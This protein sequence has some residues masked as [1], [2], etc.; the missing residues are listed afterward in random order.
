MTD[1]ITLSAELSLPNEGATRRLAEDLAAIV[2]VGEVIS[3]KGDLGSGKTTFARYFLRAL[4]DDDDLE[5]PSPTFTLAQTYGFG[6]MD[7]AHYDFYRLEDETEAGELGLDTA[8]ETGIAL[9]EWPQQAPNY[10]PDNALI[11]EI[12]SAGG[13]R[14]SVSL[15]SVRPEVWRDRLARTASIRTFLD[16]SGFSEARRR[17]LT[18]DA[19]SRAYERV[20]Q[21]GRTVILMNAPE[22]SD[23][24]PV[25][26]GLPYSRI[27][28]LA[29][30]V[31]PFVAI[32][33]ELRRQ[34]LSAPEIFAA[35]LDQGL[36]V[37]EDLGPGIVV[38]DGVPMP[39]RYKVA[40]DLL[41]RM[42]AIDWPRDLPLADQ[43]GH[44]VPLYDRTALLIEVELYCDWY[45]PFTTGEDLPAAARSEFLQLWGELVDGL[46]EAETSWVLRDFHSPNLI[47]LPERMAENRIGIIDFQDALIGPTAYDVASLCQ[48]ARVTVDAG[49]EA[50]LVDHYCALRRAGDRPFNELD[51]RSDYAVVAAQRA[52]K[53]LGIFARLNVRDGKPDYLRH[54]PR[55]VDYLNR[56]LTH[57]RLSGVKRWYE[58]NAPEPHSL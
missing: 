10:I 46:E 1:P 50:M 42:H 30:S 57:P 45:V 44:R 17:H 15:S 54:V 5:V 7:A 23:G 22:R 21:N 35:D 41:A 53:V 49:I 43:S 56:V 13:D 31:R 20:H 4:A 37:L 9:I 11:L 16:V 33:G 3:L 51:F 26:D 19:S 2:R 25:R 14:R 38:A 18:G 52:T 55:L 6:R 27:A 40:L 8:L 58:A 34:G 47:W 39:E 29:E 24:P 36:L 48:D 32:A 28:H 12:G